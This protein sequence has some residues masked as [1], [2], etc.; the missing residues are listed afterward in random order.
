MFAHINHNRLKAKG[1]G[2]HNNAQNYRNQNFE[3]LQE[4]CLTM[5]ELFEDPIFPAIPSSLGFKD[6]GPH[7]RSVQNILWQRPKVGIVGGAVGSWEGLV[8]SPVPHTT[9]S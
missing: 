2:Q 5:G 7:S 1:L 4:D 3:E 6:L 9:L 8:S